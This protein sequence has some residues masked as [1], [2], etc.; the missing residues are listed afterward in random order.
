MVSDEELREWMRKRYPA[1][2]DNLKL[3]R[4]LYERE[5]KKSVVKTSERDNRV[6][7]KDV[8]GMVGK[9]V[10]VQGLVAV[11][12]S[13]FTSRKCR[14]CWKKD[15]GEHGDLV[16]WRVSDY[17]VG[18]ETDIVK[19][20]VMGEVGKFKEIGLDD[21]VRVRGKV[22]KDNDGSVF[23]KAYVESVEVME[24][25]KV[26]RFLKHLRELNENLHE[27]VV[28]KKAS[29]FGVDLN[30]LYGRGLLVKDADG[31]VRVA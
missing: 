27:L 24:T 22:T 12:G 5:N 31:F 3:A 9:T 4:L 23:V 17:I 25:D 15:C 11:I 13:T 28:K 16:N 8:A 7:I 18:D 21:V 14:V 30:V 6:M 19:V 29:E 20:V 10:V 26:A 1:Y 2:A